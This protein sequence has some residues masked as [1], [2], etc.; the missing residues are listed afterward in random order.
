MTNRIMSTIALIVSVVLISCFFIACDNTKISQETIENQLAE[1]DGV[2]TIT[3]GNSKNVQSFKYTISNVNT[4]ILS[5]YLRM[6]TIVTVLSLNSQSLTYDELIAAGSYLTVLKIFNL[7]DNNIDDDADDTI[8]EA[9]NVLCNGKTKTFDNGWSVSAVMDK[10]D[11]KLVI[12][13]IHS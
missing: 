11:S 5:D 12:K 13:A 1:S 7:F 6:A 2:L 4:R 3:A 8:V 9:I 10:N